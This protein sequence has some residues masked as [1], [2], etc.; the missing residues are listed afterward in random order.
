ML[1]YRGASD[2]IRGFLNYLLTMIE[3]N[4]FLLLERET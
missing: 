3:E 4:H 1:I 2:M